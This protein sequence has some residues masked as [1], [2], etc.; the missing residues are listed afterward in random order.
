MA[1]EHGSVIFMDFKVIEIHRA[2]PEQQIQQI[3]LWI[4][5]FL[6]ILFKKKQKTK[7]ERRF[8]FWPRSPLKKPVRSENALDVYRVLISRCF[9]NF[10]FIGI[11]P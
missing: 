11:H 4:S 7:T 6:L 10:F 8:C 3:C 1:L 2:Q 9:I 5:S